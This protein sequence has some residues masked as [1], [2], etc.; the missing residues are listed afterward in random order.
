M[1]QADSAYAPYFLAVGGRPVLF[2]FLPVPS[3]LA[4]G[5][6]P[7]IQQNSSTKYLC[8]IEKKTQG[9]LRPHYDQR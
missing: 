3:F 9:C 8:S 1:S 6:R 2:L 5:G 7:S 4:V